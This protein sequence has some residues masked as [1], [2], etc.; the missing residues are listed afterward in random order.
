MTIDPRTIQSIQNCASEIFDELVQIRRDLHQH[1][2]LSGHEEWTTHY[3]AGKLNQIGLDVH[4]R[5][6][7]Y[8]LIA[9]LTTDPAKASVALRVDID[10]LPIQESN[11]CDYRSKIPG[12]MHACG[13]D[14]HS[15]IGVGTAIILTNL[16]TK[17]NGNVRFIFQPEEEEISGALKMIHAGALKKPTPNAI[18]GIHVAPIPVGNIALTEGLFLAGFDHYLVSLIPNQGCNKTLNALDHVA[19]KACRMILGFN[20]WHLPQNWKEEQALWERMQEGYADLQNFIIYDASLDDEQP[21]IWRGQFGLGIKTAN[22]HLRRIAIGR[23]RAYLNTL[24]RLTH[25]RYQIE[26][27]G[28]MPDM[29]NDC[30][31]VRSTRAVLAQAIGS[32]H[33]VQLKAAF[34]FNCE[35][36]AFYTKYIPG[37]MYWLGGANPAEDKFA[38]LHTP[39][40]D[41]DERC[42]LT[43]TIGMAA[44][45]IDTLKGVKTT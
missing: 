31:L 41:V 43:G 32:N 9:D 19:E 45:I 18:L 29:I 24:C 37:A 16:A 34:P 3:L 22:T 25:T 44:L 21:A 11:N 35:D 27:M 26:P 39:N 5:L 28:T 1:P 4:T 30:H 14:V 36:F 2:E 7:E 40:F 13:H 23:V 42:F 38:M 12:L 6:G 10:A 20:Q 33:I 17:L 15:A 8:G